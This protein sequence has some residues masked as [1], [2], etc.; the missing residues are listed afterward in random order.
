VVVHEVAHVLMCRL[1][2]VR[3]IRA[4]YFRFGNPAGYVMHEAP[5]RAVHGILI[6]VGPFIVN[7][8]L[9]GLIAARV[10]V[11]EVSLIPASIPDYVLIWLGVSIASRAF[12]SRQ[13]A[14]AIWHSLWSGRAN[15]LERLAGIPIVG[16]IYLGALGS[17]L[18]LDIAYGAAV[19]L[20][21]PTMV[22]KLF[23]GWS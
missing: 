18:H 14:K 22:A 2:G 10:T 12:P 21:A 16:L 13:D 20:L 23:A 3:V 6:G 9:G 4:C 17:R 5:T 7:S 19:A 11:P 1:T 8:F 15:L